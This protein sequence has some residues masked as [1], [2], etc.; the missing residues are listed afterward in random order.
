MILAAAA[1]A[2]AGI[3]Y[4]LND[5]DDEQVTHTKYET[6][7]V[8][9]TIIDKQG[10]VKCILYPKLINPYLFINHEQ[11]GTITLINKSKCNEFKLPIDPRQQINNSTFKQELSLIFFWSIPLKARLLQTFTKPCLVIENRNPLKQNLMQ[12]SV[13]IQ[14][15]IN[16]SHIP[17]EIILSNYDEYSYQL[18]R[19]EN[20]FTSNKEECDATL[21]SLSCNPMIN[22]HIIPIGILKKTNQDRFCCNEILDLDRETKMRNMVLKN[23]NLCVENLSKI[24]SESCSYDQEQ[25][26]TLENVSSIIST[27]KTNNKQKLS[28]IED[29]CENVYS[30]LF[31]HEENHDTTQFQSNNHH[32]DIDFNERLSDGII[33]QRGKQFGIALGEPMIRKNNE[34]ENLDI[35]SSHSIDELNRLLTKTNC[36]LMQQYQIRTIE[37]L[38]RLFLEQG[39][40]H[41]TD[42]M[43]NSFKVDPFIVEQLNIILLKWVKTLT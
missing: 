21:D 3:S 25:L 39:Q 32:N 17:S 12:I 13:G 14:N 41:F 18:N 22:D 16:L 36:L 34:N 1:C 27:T 19:R 2:A 31:K 15:N 33:L 10:I 9:S 24:L 26:T 7:T 23:V 20:V 35:N 6:V 37:D 5:D 38:I 43:I 8:S 42:L 28:S 11:K 29:S 30:K 40:Y 4:I